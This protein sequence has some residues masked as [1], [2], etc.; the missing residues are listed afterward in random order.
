MPDM[1]QHA[2]H[3]IQTTPEAFLEAFV[4]LQKKQV[5]G[6]VTPWILSW[7]LASRELPE[8]DRSLPFSDITVTGA[9]LKG[10]G[11]N[12]VPF[13]KNSVTNAKNTD[14]GSNDNDLESNQRV[15]F[16]GNS[17]PIRNLQLFK[18]PNDLS[19]F[20]NRGTSGIEGTLSAACGYAV[21]SEGIVFV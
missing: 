6:P 21:G 12:S 11:E 14:L 19:V 1:Y 15:L 20:C 9:F 2:T 16:S 13:N 17:S 4:K 7:N 8:P 5:S 18:K 10:I 3:F